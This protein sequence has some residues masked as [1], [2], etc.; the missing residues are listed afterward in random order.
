MICAAITNDGS[1]P[2][3]RLAPVSKWAGRCVVP[4]AK[5]VDAARPSVWY[6]Q[7]VKVPDCVESLVHRTDIANLAL[8]CAK[9]GLRYRFCRPKKAC[10]MIL[11]RACRGQCEILLVI[12]YTHMV[13]DG[14]LLE[15]LQALITEPFR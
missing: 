9:I 12:Q 15:H 8:K 7:H 13:E 6:I 4:R 2:V 11:V 14:A 1:G 5:C 3:L 10:C